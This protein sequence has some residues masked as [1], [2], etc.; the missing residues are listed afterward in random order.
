MILKKL[1][2]DGEQIKI[3]IYKEELFIIQ[4]AL[5]IAKGIWEQW[6]RNSPVKNNNPYSSSEID[7]REHLEE[8]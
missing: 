2:H 7:I 5:M 4:D 6:N 3:I 1:S 8:K